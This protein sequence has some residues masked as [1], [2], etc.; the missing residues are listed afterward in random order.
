[1]LA[2]TEGIVLR[3]LKYGESSI[4]T[5]I[6]TKEYGFRSYIMNGVR[7]SKKSKAAFFQPMNC[8][9]LVVYHRIDKDLNRI[10][11][12]RMAHIYQSIPLEIIKSSIG[13]F[14][15]EC[16]Y[17]IAKGGE[18]LDIYEI[19]SEY[20][21]LLDEAPDRY[22]NLH[23]DF[24]GRRIGTLGL[25]PELNYTQR[26]P[27]L[28]IKDGFFS[29][30]NHPKALNSDVSADIYSVFE[31]KKTPEGM[32]RTRRKR[33]IEALILYI[34]YHIPEFKTPNSYSILSEILG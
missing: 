7:K 18:Q 27:C 21:L 24:L 23:I 30:A 28:V 34:S 14:I 6:L 9:E 12:I 13:S 10:K 16:A 32:D 25:I 8:V 33:I 17:Q 2:T 22:H 11:E 1:M 29:D 19:L 3:V 31:Y 5:D 20:L 4:I 26:T 15:I